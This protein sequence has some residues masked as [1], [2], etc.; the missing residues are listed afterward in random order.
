MKEFELADVSAGE[1]ETEQQTLLRI[2]YYYCCTWYI[3]WYRVCATQPVRCIYAYTVISCLR[4]FLFQ[5]LLRTLCVV[6]KAPAPRASTR[7]LPFDDGRRDMR[8]N[9]RQNHPIKMRSTA[10]FVGNIMCDA[11]TM[12]RDW[13]LASVL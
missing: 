7:L 2:G 3:H 4:L 5:L 6:L 9:Q 13:M 11:Y 10:A 1:T 8:V 12:K